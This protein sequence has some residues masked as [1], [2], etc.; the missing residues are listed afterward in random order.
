MSLGWAEILRG[1]R[2]FARIILCRCSMIPPYTQ[3]H[4]KNITDFIKLHSQSEFAAPPEGRFA[5]CF[6]YTSLRSA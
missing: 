3:P 1:Q 5:A 4:S 6:G 2:P